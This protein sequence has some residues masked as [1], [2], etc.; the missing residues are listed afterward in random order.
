MSAVSVAHGLPAWTPT[1][2]AVMGGEP[3]ARNTAAALLREG[4]LGIWATREDA[5]L[6]VGTLDPGTIIVLLGTGTAVER[7]RAVQAVADAHPDALVV[8]AMPAD[9]PQSQLRRALQNGAAGIVLDG[10]LDR[11]L[12]A[13]VVAVAAGQLAV[14]CSLRNQVA[15]RALSHREK[16]IVSL[17]ALGLTNRQIAD[18]L[19]LAEST[20][21]THLSSAFGKL[22]AGSRAEAIQRV[23]DLEAG[24]GGWKID[25]DHVV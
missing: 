10:E 22:D 17:V 5:T 15:P 3:P 9:A 24:H 13:T 8:A 16:Q 12:V 18:K 23:L 25:A 20:V 21:K 7:G 4:G 1:M 14:P 19:Y 6:E 11:A 2:V